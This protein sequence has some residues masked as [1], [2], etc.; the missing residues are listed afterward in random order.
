MALKAPLSTSAFELERP[1]AGK[2]LKTWLSAEADEEEAASC[3]AALDLISDVG[4]ELGDVMYDVDKRV[5]CGWVAMAWPSGRR[6]VMA[7]AV[8]VKTVG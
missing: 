6:N 5:S 1:F 7:G 3:D 4:T 8:C 2:E